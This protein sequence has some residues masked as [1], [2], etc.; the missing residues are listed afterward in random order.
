MSNS[1]M[2]Q[3]TQGDRDAAQK[4]LDHAFRN[5]EVDA[6]GDVSPADILE[7]FVRYRIACMA[8]GREEAAKVCDQHVSQFADAE[9]AGGDEAEEAWHGGMAH[10]ATVLGIAIRALGDA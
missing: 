8:A 7:H 2:A 4:M 10:A 5:V 1:E 9:N 6:L 3:P